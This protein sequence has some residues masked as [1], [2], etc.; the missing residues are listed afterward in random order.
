MLPPE[1]LNEGDIEVIRSARTVT[2]L[3]L[4][5]FASPEDIRTPKTDDQRSFVVPHL[6]ADAAR[7]RPVFLDT[8]R[9]LEAVGRRLRAFRRVDVDRDVFEAA[10]RVQ[11]Q[12]DLVGFD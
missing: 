11:L 12:T 10:E 4:H 8:V 6:R 9:H 7:Q 5:P 1:R 2:V 3:H